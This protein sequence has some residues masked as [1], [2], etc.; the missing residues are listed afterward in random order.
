MHEFVNLE[1]NNV[2][3]W[4]TLLS[5][6][7]NRRDLQ[8]LERLLWEKSGLLILGWSLI[9]SRLRF[10]DGTIGFMLG[11]GFLLRNTFFKF[12]WIFGYSLKRAFFLIFVIIAERFISDTAWRRCSKQVFYWILIFER[13]S[14]LLTSRIIDKHNSAWLVFL[15]VLQFQ[16]GVELIFFLPALNAL[17]SLMPSTKTHLH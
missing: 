3:L 16:L 7:L 13:E 10:F 14:Q 4:F 1:G 8:F 17:A 2:H 11:K 6:L 5:W 12:D 15:W 9:F